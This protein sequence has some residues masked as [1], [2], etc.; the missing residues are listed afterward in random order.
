M[1]KWKKLFYFLKKISLKSIE[2]M[3]CYLFMKD[4]CKIIIFL[5]KNFCVNFKY[6]NL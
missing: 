3:K 2:I 6:R 1:N 4:Y 5:K